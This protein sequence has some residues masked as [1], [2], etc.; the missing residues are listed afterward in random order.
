MKLLGKKLLS[1][2]TPPKMA[3]VPSSKGMEVPVIELDNYKI[4][5]A[6]S[7]ILSELSYI[8]KNL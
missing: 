3:I 7:M 8:L 5:G 4:W 6:T 1:L 2:S